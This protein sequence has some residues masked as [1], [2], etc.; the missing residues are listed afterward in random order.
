MTEIRVWKLARKGVISMNCEVETQSINVNRITTLSNRKT[1]Q[2]HH[3]AF[4]QA[5]QRKPLLYLLYLF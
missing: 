4:P 5:T 2:P 1:T 3:K